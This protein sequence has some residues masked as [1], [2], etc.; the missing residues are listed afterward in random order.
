MFYRG[1]KKTFFL[2][3]LIISLCKRA[4]VTFLDGDKILYIDSL[5]TLF[6]SGM[7]LFLGAR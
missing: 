4:G 1:N 6:W 3:G 5:I 2:S 7:A